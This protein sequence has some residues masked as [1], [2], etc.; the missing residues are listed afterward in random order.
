VRYT[1]QS[2]GGL[3]RLNPLTGATSQI[4][5]GPGSAP[6]R[7]IVGPDGAAWVTDGGLN[8]IVPVDPLTEMVT[9]FPLP[10]GTGNANLNTGVLDNR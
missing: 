4:S 10:P 6:H 1:A 7:V 2:S 3:G 9:R 5:L 8:A